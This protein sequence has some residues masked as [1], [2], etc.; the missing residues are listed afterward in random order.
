MGGRAPIATGIPGLP[1]EGR[2]GGLGRAHVLVP[3]S[4]V[5]EGP[6]APGT[7]N[8]PDP[9]SQPLGEEARF[10]NGDQ[11]LERA[12]GPGGGGGIRPKKAAA[13]HGCPAGVKM[14][15]VSVWRRERRGSLSVKKFKSVAESWEEP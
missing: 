8:W 6:A 4:L 15:V 1:L 14:G 10:R 5:S 13:G 7:G 11:G 2:A 3:V 12:L 9:V